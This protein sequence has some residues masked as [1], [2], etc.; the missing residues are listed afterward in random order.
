MQVEGPPLWAKDKEGFDVG[1]QALWNLHAGRRIIVCQS[2]AVHLQTMQQ[3]SS[4][5]GHIDSWEAGRGKLLLGE[6]HTSFSLGQQIH[7]HLRECC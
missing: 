2:V 1:D 6:G 7:A 5:N 4:G 3:R